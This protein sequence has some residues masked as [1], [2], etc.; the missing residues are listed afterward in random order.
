MGDRQNVGQQ[1]VPL[2]QPPSARYPAA[3]TTQRSAF[4]IVLCY[5]LLGNRKPAGV[6]LTYLHVRQTHL[7]EVFH[8]DLQV[9]HHRLHVG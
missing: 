6:P 3:P 8:R 7:G 1:E 4:K 9:L 5:R 2:R